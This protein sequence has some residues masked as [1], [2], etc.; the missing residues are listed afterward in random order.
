MALQIEKLR[1]EHR[2][3]GFNCGQEPLH[4][5]LI[6]VALPSQLANSAQTYLALSGVGVVGYYALTYG[7]VMRPSGCARGSPGT[8]SRS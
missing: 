4:R 8:R 6:R 5:F 3:D 2:V 7:D 1:R